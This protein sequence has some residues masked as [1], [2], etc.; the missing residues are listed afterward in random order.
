[1]RKYIHSNGIDWTVLK[2]E[3]IFFRR[4]SEMISDIVSMVD[5]FNQKYFLKDKGK[6][7][8]IT[9]SARLIV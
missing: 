4:N 9:Q 5:T 6:Y 1:M 2:Y 7:G 8:F 3:E